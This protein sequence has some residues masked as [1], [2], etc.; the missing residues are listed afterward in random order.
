[1]KCDFALPWQ[2]GFQDP[3]TPIMEGIIDLYDQVTFYLILVLV[4]VGWISLAVVIHFKQQ[5]IWQKYTSHGTVL[6]IVWTI[7]PAAILLSILLPSFQLLYLSDEV[8]DPALTLKTIGRQWYWS[9]EYSDYTK[10]D[11]ETLTFDSYMLPEESLMEGG[12]RLLEVDN[13]VVLPIHTHIR[14]LTTASDVLHSWAV[15]SL[16][17]KLDAVPGRLNQTSLFIKRPGVYF[18]QCSELCGSHHSKMPIVIEAVSIEQY[19]EWLKTQ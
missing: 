17:I 1:M 8:I 2:V 6:E 16:G 9:Y 18:G 11:E 14:V 10:S 15:P 13:R 19:V 7:A 5:P 4:L 12:L 3:A